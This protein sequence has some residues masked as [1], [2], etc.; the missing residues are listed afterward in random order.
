MDLFGKKRIAQLERE[1]NN[2]TAMVKNQTND[3]NRLEASELRLMG[4][5][6]DMDTL[7]FQMSQCSD[8]L[9]M[10]PYFNQLQEPMERRRK[11]ESNRIQTLLIPEM[12][13]AY[14]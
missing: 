10:R 12:Q 13:K 9:S 6:R 8:W 2:L 1:I 14:R 5:I 11:D 4:Q 7:I 3:I